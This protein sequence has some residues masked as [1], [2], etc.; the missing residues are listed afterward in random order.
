MVTDN[1]T[2]GPSGLYY[3]SNNG[4]IENSQNIG[5]ANE[6]IS[7]NEHGKVISLADNEPLMYTL[8][9]DG[10]VENAVENNTLSSDEEWHNV[11][12]LSPKLDGETNVALRADGTMLYGDV[13]WTETMEN[14]N[15]IIE[16]EYWQ[17]IQQGGAC[18]IGIKSDGTLC[19][20]TDSY[21]SNQNYGMR[22]DINEVLERFSDV[23]KLDFNMKFFSGASYENSMQ[24]AALTNHG[25]VMTYINGVFDEYEVKDVIDIEIQ[26][27]DGHGV[28]IMPEV[29]GDG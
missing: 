14:W 7:L 19:A 21:L 9:E 20:A 22:G 10:Y 29:S 23:K 16:F 8:R 24:I 12:Q 11:V 18:I 26:E 5:N 15:N 13:H 27:D 6:N 17:D 28:V 1:Y 3:I 25:T 2:G 4:I